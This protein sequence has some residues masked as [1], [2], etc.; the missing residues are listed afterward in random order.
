[1]AAVSLMILCLL[2]S[3]GSATAAE[4][5]FAENEQ[6]AREALGPDGPAPATAAEAPES[7]ESLSDVTS[8]ATILADGVMTGARPVCRSRGGRGS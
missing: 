1:M 2:M 6:R 3:M 4:D 5:A 7:A 8:G